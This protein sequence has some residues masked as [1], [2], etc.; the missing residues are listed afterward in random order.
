MFESVNFISLFL[1]FIVIGL[2][3]YWLY[4]LFVGYILLVSFLLFIYILYKITIYDLPES[5]PMDD[6]IFDDYSPSWTISKSIVLTALII[7]VPYSFIDCLF[8]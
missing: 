5:S 8:S 4:D 7:V 1:R 6:N 2:V 3:E